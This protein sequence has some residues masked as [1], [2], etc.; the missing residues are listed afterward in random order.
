MPATIRSFLYALPAKLR[1]EDKIKHMVWSF[2]LTA[3]TGLIMPLAL[4]VCTVFLIGL[5][6]ECWDYRYGS[7]FC[8]FDMAGNFMGMAA[9]MAVMSVLTSDLVRTWAA[10]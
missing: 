5:L 8:F 9:G 7:G 10:L 4:A 2:W 6:K 3:A 1:E